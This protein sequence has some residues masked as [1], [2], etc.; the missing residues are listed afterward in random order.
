[1]AAGTSSSSLDVSSLPQYESTNPLCAYELGVQRENVYLG[2]WKYK[3]SS[4]L[5]SLGA[6]LGL[7]NISRFAIAKIQFGE[8][9]VLQFLFISL[10]FGIPLFAFHLSMGQLLNQGCV[11]MWEISPL[12]KGIGLALLL[13][14][15]L[16]GV[17][18]TIGISWM[19]FYLKDSFISDENFYRWAV[20]Y[21]FYK[22][23]N[24]NFED[25]LPKSTSKFNQT[26]ED[27][28]NKHVYQG[29]GSFVNY[30]SSNSTYLNFFH[31]TFIWLLVHYT[32]RKGLRVYG[33]AIFLYTIIPVTGLFLLT[34]RIFTLKNSI[35]Q[36]RYQNY[37]DWTDFFFNTKSWAA[38]FWESFSTWGL[39][40][41]AAM[42]VSAHNRYKHTLYKDAFVVVL[43]T[44]TMLILAGC[45]GNTCYQLLLSAGYAYVPSSFEDP[46]KY[47]FLK[48]N[49]SS[50]K[51]KWTKYSPLLLGERALLPEA[52]VNRE[53]GYQVLRLATELVPSI[54][55][56]LGP[57][58]LSP[59]WAILFYSSMFLIGMAQ[60][61]AI[62]HSCV[63]G[64]SAA[65]SKATGSKNTHYQVVL[66]SCA[67]AFLLGLPLLGANGIKT[68]YFLDYTLGAGWWMVVLYVLE[69]TALFMFR[70]RPFTGETV[71][72][73]LFSQS[74]HFSQLYVAPWC[75][76]MWNVTIPI[77]LLYLASSLFKNGGYKQLFKWSNRGPRLY[78]PV[79][80][81]ETG[82]VLQLTPLIIVVLVGICQIYKYL[83]TGPPDIFER[84]KLLYRPNVVT[85]ERSLETSASNNNT[86]PPAYT[87][88]PSYS[89][90]T[91]RRLAKSVLRHSFRYRTLRRE[92][93]SS[94]SSNMTSSGD[95]NEG[96]TARRSLRFVSK[97]IFMRSLALKPRVYTE[98]EHIMNNRDLFD[99]L[100]NG[101]GQP[102]KVSG[103][104]GSVKTSETPDAERK[105]KFTVMTCYERCSPMLSW[106]SLPNLNFNEEQPPLNW[107]R[108]NG[109]LENL[110]IKGKS[111]EAFWSKK[112]TFGPTSCG[113][114]LIVFE[115]NIRFLVRE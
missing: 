92:A 99:S 25:L 111:L 33:K 5:A 57:E 100:E 78:F 103:R 62:W 29:Y 77:T 115:E 38:A 76:F 43:I 23:R 106:R 113:N 36:L 63:T 54:F 30:L 96:F 19:L 104:W 6:T 45:L 51:L 22:Y 15:F 35:K 74:G 50:E 61:L 82:A 42:Q 114:G 52:N 49:N 37:V 69:I 109:S 56:I 10:I 67:T 81:R 65:L 71:A 72:A 41:A 84:I 73:T 85:T 79:R 27:Y 75:S 70:G 11:Q 101:N 88:P 58:K 9:F 31:L 110:L 2:H 4:I 107:P 3:E 93:R 40:G 94:L 105:C 46:S 86:E 87:P 59:L 39:L 108:Q 14:H 32:L 17:Y 47:I 95:G 83:S 20:P 89:T 66:C 13:A 16:I 8:T 48:R 97:D 53:S 102:R 98:F 90:A 91:G 24:Y 21:D 28:F 80:L 44:L 68:I 60:L 34:L 55:A 112:Q 12:F 18:T 7:C 64:L 26:A 1:M